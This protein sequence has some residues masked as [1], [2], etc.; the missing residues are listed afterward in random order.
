MNI[1]NRNLKFSSSLPVRETTTEIIIHCSATKEGVNVP[2]ESIHRMHIAN[3][4][5]GIG[6]NFYIDIEGNVFQGRPEYAAGAHTVGHNNKAIGIC[7]CGGIGKNGKPKDTRTPAQH[8]AMTRLVGEL[9]S[10]YPKA[11]V[12][13]HNQWANKACPCFNASDWAEEMGWPADHTIKRQ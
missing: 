7:Y 13:G 10:R 8:H 5:A 11:K 4:W 12:S 6:Y 9:L 3:G 1:I 2:V